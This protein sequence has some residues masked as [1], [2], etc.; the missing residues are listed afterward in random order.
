MTKVQKSIYERLAKVDLQT[1]IERLASDI[2]VTQTYKSEYVPMVDVILRNADKWSQRQPGL[3]LDLLKKIATTEFVP[4]E[5]LEKVAPKALE[6]YMRYG[7]ELYRTPHFDNLFP[8]YGK[9]HPN[10]M[11]AIVKGLPTVEDPAQ[12]IITIMDVHHKEAQYKMVSLMMTRDWANV[13]KMQPVKAMV[14]MD[15]Y[16]QAIRRLGDETIVNNE[17]YWVNKAFDLMPN[18]AQYKGSQSFIDTLLQSLEG[19]ERQLAVVDYAIAN[20]PALYLDKPVSFSKLRALVANDDKRRPALAK[21][22]ADALMHSK[23]GNSYFIKTMAETILETTGQDKTAVKNIVDY[24][25][26]VIMPGMTKQPHKTT[27]VFNRAGEAFAHIRHRTYTRDQLIKHRER[28]WTSPK[29]ISY[30][31]KVLEIMASKRP[32]LSVAAVVDGKK[33]VVQFYIPV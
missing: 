14:M 30:T 20:L 17:A 8:S 29:V 7:W 33:P 22:F 2:G 10:I 25:D 31:D 27:I 1:G 26:V 24:G 13:V 3:V 12:A 19:D 23:D 16:L 5:V 15:G 4:S 11:A 32:D 18:S 6:I 21:T 9:N 28:H